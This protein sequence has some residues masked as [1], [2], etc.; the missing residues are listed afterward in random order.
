M[1]LHQPKLLEEYKRAG[2]GGIGGV[3][4]IDTFLGVGE[5]VKSLTKHFAVQKE[6]VTIAWRDQRK[7]WSLGQSGSLNSKKIDTEEIGNSSKA[8]K[9]V[10][11]SELYQL[12]GMTGEDFT[13]DTTFNESCSFNKHED[14]KREAIRE[15]QTHLKSLADGKPI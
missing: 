4:D 11:V 15:N 1:M 2:L 12:Y 13:F 10:G 3:G 5:V 8:T 7:S 9:G 14:K 6:E